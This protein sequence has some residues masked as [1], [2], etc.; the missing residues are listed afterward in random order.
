MNG[1][2]ITFINRSSGQRGA[3]MAPPP[4]SRPKEVTTTRFQIKRTTQGQKCQD[5]AAKAFVEDEVDD[6]I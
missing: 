4:P 5:K 6:L 1:C 3:L 2:I